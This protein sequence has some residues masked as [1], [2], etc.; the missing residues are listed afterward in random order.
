MKSCVPLV[1]KDGV[2]Y[3]KYFCLKMSGKPALKKK[4]GSSDGVY[5]LEN[6]I[7]LRIPQVSS[8]N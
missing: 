7:I 6:N 4:E 5:E 1:N 3:T 2:C 8:F